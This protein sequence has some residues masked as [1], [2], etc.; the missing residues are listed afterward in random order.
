[1]YLLDQ[2]DQGRIQSANKS[3]ESLKQIAREFD[4]RAIF[5][6]QGLR[7][8]NPIGSQA[9]RSFFFQLLCWCFVIFQ[10][11]L[12]LTLFPYV[13]H[14]DAS[15]ECNLCQEASQVVKVL[16]DSCR[17]HNSSSFQ[18]VSQF[19]HEALQQLPLLSLTDGNSSRRTGS[20]LM[21]RL[22][23]SHELQ[24]VV[25]CLSHFAQFIMMVTL[26]FAGRNA[27]CFAT[28]DGIHSN[29]YSQ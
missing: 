20:K 2:L 22:F 9:L 23:Q 7:P 4:D 16:I 28:L 24:M 26:H 19:L 25:D 11:Q 14:V 29:A 5:E 10:T 18:D 3:E 12:L 27:A 6:A 13:S 1:M 15:H 21:V 8:A 17:R